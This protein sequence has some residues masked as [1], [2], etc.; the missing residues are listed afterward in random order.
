MHVTALRRRAAAAVLTVLTTAACAAEPSAAPSPPTAGAST[1]A[2][3]QNLTL[4]Y[5]LPTSWANVGPLKQAVA[6]YQEST[7]V[8]VELQA[9]PDDQYNTVV[10]ARLAGGSG[11]DIFAGAYNVFDVASSMVPIDDPGIIARMDASG[12]ASIT[13]T[14]GKIYS[15]PSP[16]PRAT[17]GVFYNKKVFADAGL[18]PPTSLAGMTAALQTIAGRGIVPLSVSGKDGW[19]LLQH[20]NAVNVQIISQ[21]RDAARRLTTNTATWTDFPVLRQ[22]YDALAGWAERGYLNKDALTATYEQAVDAVANG[23]AAMLINGSWAIGDL[24]KANPAAADGIGFFPLPAPDGPAMLGISGADQLHISARSAHIDAAK[25]FLRYLNEPARAQAWMDASPGVPLYRDTTMNADAPA[26]MRDIE[27]ALTDHPSTLA[28]D[29]AISVPAP[30][31]EMIAAYQ[32]LLAGRITG[33]A[34]LEKQAQ[35]FIRNGKRAKAA[36]F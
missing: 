20:R 17:F 9:V 13:Y 3:R 22:H 15:Y 29:D 18:K 4:A 24:I 8:E 21:D 28:L 36:G 33:K 25:A 23:R 11:V 10:L 7:G 34:L 26:A 27:T 32:Q 12:V 2:S 1:A 5:I 19:T 16:A 30:Q 31:D 35:A 14:D 6:A